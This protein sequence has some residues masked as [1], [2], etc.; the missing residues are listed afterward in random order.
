M[1]QW[2]R[3]AAARTAAKSPAM[4]PGCGAW[5][6]ALR[7]L[8]HSLFPLSVYAGHSHCN[9]CWSV[10]VGCIL[11]HIMLMSIFLATFAVVA[12]SKLITMPW[13]T[14]HSA[15][16]APGGA[17]TA[18]KWLLRIARQPYSLP[19]TLSLPLLFPD[20]LQV[21]SE[22]KCAFDGLQRAVV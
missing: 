12:G 17:A 5:R 10:G 4:G 11:P 14:C 8:A 18:R 13:F 19:F 1:P 20:K 2:T 16:I 3:E 6:S 15:P 21:Q 9:C 22:L 7:Y